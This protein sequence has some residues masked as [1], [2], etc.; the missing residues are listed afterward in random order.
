MNAETNQ[1]SSNAFN[2]IS[3][4]LLLLLGVSIILWSLYSS[5]NIFTGK[6]QAPQI[7]ELSGKE[8]LNSAQN[9]QGQMEQVVGQVIE[10]QLKGLLPDNVLPIILNLSM[11]LM[12]SALA[13]F[14]G[15]Q[16]ASLGIKII[17]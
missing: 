8:T 16:I 17:K 11:W 2:R 4:V 10:E 15:T 7:F 1:K 14:T 12:F 5:Y 6:V 3:G 9:E 13:V